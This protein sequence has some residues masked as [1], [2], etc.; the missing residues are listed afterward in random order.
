MV[1][2]KATFPNGKIYIGKTK[3]FIDRV[4]KHRYSIR[5]DGKTKM[6]RAIKKYGF[7]NIIW[8][9]IY[10]FIDGDNINNK[11]K[12]F[13][14]YYNSIKCGYNITEGGDGGD[15]IS[16]NKNRLNIIKKTMKS[17]GYDINKYV[18]ISNEM[19]DDI[20]ED[21]N[22]NKLS[23]RELSKKYNITRNRLNRF[24]SSNDIKIDSQR[25]VQT[26]SKTLTNIEKNN[27]IEMF[28]NKQSIKNISKEL[29]LSKLIV[30]R[31]L[32]DKN[33]RI[34]KRFKDGKRYDGTQPKYKQLMNK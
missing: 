22:V 20:I 29:K 16:N 34:S 28:G 1:I 21:Y 2:Y 4:E 24:L 13:I 23:L 31:F 17:K 8:E 10:A 9:I 3:N 27:I 18:V 5:Y 32:H 11:E 25:C 30:S 7:Y 14:Q 12:E 6:I 15:T 33:L 19:S 26:N